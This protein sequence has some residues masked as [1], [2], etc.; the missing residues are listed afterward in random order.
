MAPQP[1]AFPPAPPPDTFPG[2][3]QPGSPTGQP[4]KAHGKTRWLIGGAAVAAVL[5]VGAVI[6]A[7]KVLGPSDPGC[8]AYAGTALTAY[9]QTIRDL[10]AQASQAKLTGDMTTAIAALRTATA[11]AQSAAVRSALGGLL[12]ELVTVRTDVQKGSVPAAT[13]GA[14]NTA[15]K[16]ADNAC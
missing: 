6:V 10:N 11:Q 8:K 9:N 1:G 12:A 15:A 4:R 5:A 13:V 3:S 7:P 2:A 16:T 14:I